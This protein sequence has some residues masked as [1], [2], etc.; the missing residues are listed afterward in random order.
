MKIDL[1]CNIKESFGQLEPGDVFQ[2]LGRNIV[3]LKLESSIG[4]AVVLES[5]KIHDFDDF[6]I[7]KP[8]NCKVVLNQ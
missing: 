6:T 7:I 4:K 1:G 3:Y 5:G 8:L 2:V